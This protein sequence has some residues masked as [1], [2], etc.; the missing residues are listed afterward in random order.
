MKKIL[1]IFAACVITSGMLF[2]ASGNL[3]G[4]GAQG[5]LS[6]GFDLTLDLGAGTEVGWFES[7]P[8]AANWG[9]ASLT[10]VQ[11]D[12]DRAFTDLGTPVTLWAGVKSNENAQLKLEVSGSPL[13]SASVDTT[14]GVH[15]VSDA[16]GFGTSS[17][18]WDGTGSD[19]LS[20]QED[21]VVST[22]RVIAAKVD[23]TMDTEDY[24]S[25]LSADDYSADITL[26]VTSVS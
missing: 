18:E 10:E 20:K 13:V 12:E 1:I 4:D 17:I 21:S 26:T 3:V 8:T 19:T 7:K 22:S 15:A 24:N 23:F 14:I 16:D 5:S 6:A 2:A 25:A 11:E 9:T